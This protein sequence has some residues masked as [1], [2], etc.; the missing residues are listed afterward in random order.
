VS[1]LGEKVP[2][3]YVPGSRVSHCFSSPQLRTA[4][5]AFSSAAACLACWVA[6][7]RHCRWQGGQVAAPPHASASSAAG[8]GH[9]LPAQAQAGSCTLPHPP[10]L[11]SQ[12]AAQCAALAT[13][14]PPLTSR[15]AA[16]WPLRACFSASHCSKVGAPRACSSSRLHAS[17]HTPLCTHAPPQASTGGQACCALRCLQPAGAGVPPPPPNPPPPTPPSHTHSSSIWP[18]PWQLQPSPTFAPAAAAPRC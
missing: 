13:P 2:L 4:A 18:H 6:A 14:P 9:A 11:S 7:A 8:A 12:P 5:S 15:S 3:G 16:S 1:G 10:S 17:T